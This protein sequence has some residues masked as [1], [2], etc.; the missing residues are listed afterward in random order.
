MSQNIANTSLPTPTATQD[1]TAVPDEAIQSTSE[2]EQETADMKYA[3]CQ[4]WKQ[5]KKEQKAAKEAAEHS[6]GPG[7]AEGSKAKDKAKA[8]DTVPVGPCAWCV[9]AGVECMFELAKASKQGKKSCDQCSGLKEQCVLPGAKKKKEQGAKEA[10]SPRASDKKKWAQ[11][12]SLEVEVQ[13][14]PSRSKN[15]AGEILVARGLHAI[16]ATIDRH[17]NKMPKHQEIT[18]ETQH[19]QRQ[20]NDHLYELLQE[21]E[22]WQVAEVGESSDEESTGME[23]SDGETD[24]DMEGEEAPESDLESCLFVSLHEGA[25]GSEGQR[26]AASASQSCGVAEVTRVVVPAGAEEVQDKNAGGRLEQD[27]EEDMEERS[28]KVGFHKLPKGVNRE[29]S[30][31]DH[32]SKG[33]LSEDVWSVTEP[34][35][36]NW[37]G[38]K[39][40]SSRTRGK[41]VHREAELKWERWEVESTLGQASEVVMKASLREMTEQWNE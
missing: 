31:G 1:W 4:C 39:S 3:K 29:A 40:A 23:S 33:H 22:Y 13:A 32:E 41:R 38:T 36:E 20:F 2:D 19:V 24:K 8:H 7:L 35:S 17:T 10:T 11:A 27:D 15:M 9:R 14:R 12:K 26:V 25:G 37:T 5:A 28:W 34:E 16:M 6:G 21:M 18:K 30:V